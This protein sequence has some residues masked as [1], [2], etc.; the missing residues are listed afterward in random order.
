MPWPT[1]DFCELFSPRER[2]IFEFVVSGELVMRS[3]ARQSTQDKSRYDTFC[4]SIGMRQDLFLSLIATNPD[5]INERADH[6]LINQSI[7]ERPPRPL[8]LSLLSHVKFGVYNTAASKFCA[9]D[10]SLCGTCLV[11]SICEC[12]HN[13]QNLLNVDLFIPHRV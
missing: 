1:D 2:N 6:L 11:M 8:L 12:A 9:A 4:C 5:G 3:S 10:L 7:S 13:E